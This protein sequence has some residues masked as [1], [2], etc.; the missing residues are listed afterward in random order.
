MGEASSVLMSGGA[1]AKQVEP[2]N[3]AYVRR[4]VL[5]ADAPLGQPIGEA[6]TPDPG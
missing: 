1:H 2:G 3:A 5:D 4:R 6:R